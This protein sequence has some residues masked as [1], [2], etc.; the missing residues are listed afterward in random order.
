MDLL[1]L[2]PDLVIGT[3]LLC[4]SGAN[5]DVDFEQDLLRSDLLC[6]IGVLL[7]SAVELGT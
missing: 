5:K 1:G 6:S 2:D 4:G 3:E 7:A